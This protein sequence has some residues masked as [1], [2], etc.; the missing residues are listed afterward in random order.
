MGVHVTPECV[1]VTDLSL[2]L[3]GSAQLLAAYADIRSQLMFQCQQGDICYSFTNTNPG[4]PSAQLASPQP[5][6]FIL[7]QGN[8]F[9][10]AAGVPKNALYVCGTNG[11]KLVAIAG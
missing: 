1:P 10:A 2:T 6:V 3:N 5:G 9:S 7:Y 4:L 11:Q 8:T